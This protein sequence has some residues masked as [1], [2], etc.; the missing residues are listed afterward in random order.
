MGIGIFELFILLIF[1]NLILWI[2]ALFDVLR[3]EFTWG[4]KFIWFIVITFIPL[5][6]TIT[7]FFI[8]KKKE[9]K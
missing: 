5:F 3:R 2:V 1:V 7:Y 6:G 4:N 9:L 8:G